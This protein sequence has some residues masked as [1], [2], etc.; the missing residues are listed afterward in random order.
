M[1]LTP[2][3]IAID[4]PSASGKGSI[5]RKV[6]AALGFH[7]LDSGAL[8]RIVGLVAS[9]RGVAL[10]KGP[11]V[12]RLVEG[13]RIEFEGDDKSEG[14]IRVD[15]EDM[16]REIRLESTGELA[17]QVA[18]HPEVRQALVRLQ[19]SFRKWPG[20][21]ADGRDMGSVI[22][23]DAQVKVYLTASPEERA[24]RRYKQLKEKG[25]SVNLA[26]LSAEIAERDYR[27]R[28]RSV[29]PLR[30]AADAVELD[31]TDLNIEQVVE[32]VMAL[33]EEKLPGLPT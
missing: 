23:P 33:V 4:G 18:A 21:L 25:I 15:G 16:T 32:Q 5:S 24:R 1:E 10:D 3:V 7:L 13:L 12:A 17:S 22:F 11:L 31:T 26:A 9:R 28:T 27:D 8:Y 30:P 20:L 14:I 19:R 29:S 2:P 6:A